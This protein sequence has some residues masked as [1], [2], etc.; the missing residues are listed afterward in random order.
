M[1][2]YLLL[3]LF[4]SALATRTYSQCT[5]P[6][7]PNATS[8]ILNAS[9]N[10]LSVYYDTTSNAPATNIYYL[11]ILSTS[12]PLSGSPTNGTSYNLGDPIGGGNVI[13]YNKNYIQKQT[14]LTPGATY[15]VYLYSARTVCTGEPFYSASYIVDT[16]TMFSG[17]PG[18]PAG[19]YD[20]AAAQNCSILKTTLFNIIKP[21]VPNPTPT[22]TGLWG[23]YFITDDRLNDAANK[24]IVGDVYTANL[25]GKE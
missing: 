18:I 14:G 13:F 1:R 2:K 19:Y 23:A 20:P 8:L 10:Q 22:Y 4:L 24:T 6:N 5:A 15:Y 3:V 9:D 7:T 21:T 25:S 11:G 16:I 17:A 12:S